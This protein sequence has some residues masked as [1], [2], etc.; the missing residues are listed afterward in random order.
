MNCQDFEELVLALARNQLLDAV[1]REQGLDHAEVCVRCKA[2]L[3]EERA[4]LTGV[5][6]VVAELAEQDAPARVEARL[7]MAFRQQVAAAASPAVI[8][9]AWPM[10]V[11]TRD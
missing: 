2:H 8:P 1:D 3:A 11:K 7:L 5:H 9:G 6:V 10:P 4:F